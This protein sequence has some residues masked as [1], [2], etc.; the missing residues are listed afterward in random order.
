M[1]ASHVPRG[2]E[3]RP[4]LGDRGPGALPSSRWEQ[5]PQSDHDSELPGARAGCWAGPCLQMPAMIFLA[6]APSP[7]SFNPLSATLPQPGRVT[8]FSKLYLLRSRDSV[9]RRSP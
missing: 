9:A 8:L 1:G 7:S 2:M 6:L 4:L 5:S 3:D